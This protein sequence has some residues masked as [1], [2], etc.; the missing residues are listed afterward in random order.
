MEKNH[1]VVITRYG[2]PEVL[3]WI[4]EP[5]PMPKEEQVLVKVLAT[6]VAHGDI[7]IRKGILVPPLQRLPLTPGFEIVGRVEKVGSQVIGFKKGQ[8]VAALTIVGGNSEYICVHYK[9]LVSVPQ[10][11][12]VEEAVSLVLNYLTAYQMLHRYAKVQPGQN[13]LIHGASGGVG[14]ALLQLGKMIGVN[15][16]GTAS[17]AKHE[18]VARYGAF[19]IDY[20]QTD[21]VEVINQMVPEGVDAVFDPIG[22]YHFNLSYRV[23]RKRGILIGYGFQSDGSRRSILQSLARLISL[24]IRPDGKR[25]KFYSLVVLKKKKPNWIKE[26]LSHLFKLTAD[27]AIQPII[28][29]Q[30]PLAEIR[31]AHETFE[32]GITIGKIILVTEKYQRHSK[33]ADTGVQQPKAK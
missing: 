21:F 25:S 8:L 11:V 10:S 32:N 5:M 30:F 6:G 28:Y 31:S 26:D 7:L 33:Q 29:Q 13:L 15:M 22:G 19:P 3:Q 23:L 14:T 9:D 1:R 20:R 12:G 27:G 18:I 2:G 16:Y 24:K 17:S 4:E